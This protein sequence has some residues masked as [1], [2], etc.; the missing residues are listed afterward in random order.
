[1][2]IITRRRFDIPV[3]PFTDLEEF[4]KNFCGQIRTQAFFAE[5][6]TRW[7]C[8]PCYGSGRILAESGQVSEDGRKIPTVITCETCGGSQLGTREA[9]EARYNEEI[10]SWVARCEYYRRLIEVHPFAIQK[11][12]EVEL[13][14][15]DLFGISPPSF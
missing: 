15:I 9:C 2:P 13:E 10:Q 11:L 1:M 8:I 12:T 3:R 5:D 6:E 7:P 14:S 4:R